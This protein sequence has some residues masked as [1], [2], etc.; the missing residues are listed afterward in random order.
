M[1][2]ST[3]S[4]PEGRPT[5]ALRLLHAE[6]G[7]LNRA[8]GSARFSMGRTTVLA[9]VFG[10]VQMGIRS[11][12]PEKAVIEVTISS[13]EK[14]SGS[15]HF[16][17]AQYLIKGALESVVLTSLHPRTV[18][19]VAIQVI[20]SDGSLISAGINAACFALLDAGVPCT[21]LI[22]SCTIAVAQNGVMLYD[23][24][25]QEEVVSKYFLR[26]VNLVESHFILFRA[27]HAE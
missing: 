12:Q 5:N 6:Q 20:E 23:P 11:E 15:A 10:P 18:I 1:T 9:A 16:L 19:R 25:N 17:Q 7:L 4:R 3:S 22:T 26:V 8:D 14:S 27:L 24:D 2:T 13:S 21:S